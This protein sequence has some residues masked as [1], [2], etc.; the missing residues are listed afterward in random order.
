MNRFTSPSRKARMALTSAAVAATALVALPTASAFAANPTDS[1]SGAHFD[2]AKQRC[3]EAVTR[4][5]GTTTKD[6]ARVAKATEAPEADRTTLTSELQ[7]TASRLT[8]SAAA[9]QAATTGDALKTACKDMVTTT[10][11]YV[12]EGPKVASLTAT[13]W[14]AKADAAVAKHEGQLP[15]IIE[16]AE[17]RGVPAEKIDDAKA[18]LADASAALADAHQHVD[19]LADALLPITPAQVYD[20]S[21]KAQL[22]H[23]HTRLKAALDDAKRIRADLKAAVQDLRTH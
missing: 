8:D 6:L 5:Q 23:A 19:G 10:R 21:A 2:R 14:L 1:G 16:R 9:I 12:L 4:R 3:T 17:K 22:Q 11:V 20:G 15:R 13:S 7:A 18:K